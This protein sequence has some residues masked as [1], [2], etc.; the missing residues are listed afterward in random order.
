M[1][2]HIKLQGQSEKQK[3]S[4]LNKIKNMLEDENFKCEF[5]NSSDYNIL[6]GYK[7]PIIDGVKI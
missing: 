1:K 3:Q 2:I 5:Q 7:T 6:K 4:I